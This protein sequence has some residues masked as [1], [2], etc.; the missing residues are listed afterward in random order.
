MKSVRV[1]VAGVGTWG[2]NHARVIAALPEAEVSGFHDARPERAAEIAGHHGGRPFADLDGLI[3]SSDAVIVAVPTTAHHEVA[4]RAFRAGRHVL[5]E[6][7]IASSLEEADDMVRCAS[8]AGL[9]L[10]VGHLERFNPAV[11]A[12]LARSGRPRFVEVHRL[13]PFHV[14]GLDVSVVLDLMIHDLDILLTLARSPLREVSAVGVPVLSPSIDIANARLLFEDGCVANLT[15]SRISVK[16]TRK[17]RVFEKETYFSVDFTNQEIVCY[18]RTGAVPTPERLTPE[19]FHE[20]VS[21]EE[22]EIRREEPL[23]LEVERFLSAVRGEEVSYV[24][25]GEGRA[26][27]AAAIRILREV[28]A[29]AGPNA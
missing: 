23:K 13:S 1:G 19:S 21:R 18:R 6:K 26:A 28:D 29:D 14:R 9:V 25:G 24:T 10:M 22:I 2:A 15:A 4:M 11:E 20:L 8:D 7:P 17:I 12:L 3:E 27:L 16:K 5:V